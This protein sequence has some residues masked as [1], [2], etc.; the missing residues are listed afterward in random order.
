MHDH[1]DHKCLSEDWLLDNL[2][3]DWTYDCV[4]GS[5]DGQAGFVIQAP[6]PAA[7]QVGQLFI[8][9]DLLKQNRASVSAANSFN[10][11]LIERFHLISLIGARISELETLKRQQAIP[12]NIIDEQLAIYRPLYDKVKFA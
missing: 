10:F 12:D 6:G 5:D 4:L 7:G 2:P 8:P 1:G 11:H 3:A 9:L